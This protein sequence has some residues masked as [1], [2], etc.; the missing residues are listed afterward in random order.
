[1]LKSF[2]IFKRNGAHLVKKSVATPLWGKCEVATHISKNGTWESSGTP[3]NLERN[4]KGQH[5]L[6]WRVLYTVEKVL[7]CR[8]IKWLRMSHLDICST[9][10]GPKKGRESN[11]QFDS[12]PLK[13]RNRP[14]SDACRWSVT[15]RWK[16]LEENYNFGLD[17]VLIRVWGETLWTPKVLGVQTGTISGLLCS[18]P[19]V[20]QVFVAQTKDLVH[21]LTST[22]FLKLAS[23]QI[24]LELVP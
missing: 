2:S 3:K 18:S 11:W 24:N 4:C 19:Q 12:R 20:V 13:V 9:S 1:M 14:D 23:L 15:H 6:H 8:C 16:D 21:I 5:T 10:Y 7:K 22:S 17:L